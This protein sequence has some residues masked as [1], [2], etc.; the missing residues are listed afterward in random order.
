MI[1]PLVRRIVGI[2]VL[3]GVTAACLPYL[4]SGRSPSET[5]N[6]LGISISQTTDKRKT[7]ADRSTVRLQGQRGK[8]GD[9]L[10]EAPD[11][12]Q[13]DV[14][15]PDGKK[16][17]ADDG[18]KGRK[19]A[20]T[21]EGDPDEPV[22]PSD[23][24][25]RTIQKQQ[26]EEEKAQQARRQAEAARKAEAEK[27]AAADAR[28]RKEADERKAAEA[29]KLAE[30]QKAARQSVEEKK[31]AEKRAAEEK[32][33]SE[34]ERIAAARKAAE[35]K[36]AAEKKAAEE[37]S[38]TAAASAAEERKKAQPAKAAAEQKAFASG[39]NA[40]KYRDSLRSNGYPNARME[41][42]TR[43]GRVLFRV[44]PGESN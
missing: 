41:P 31:A 22:M 9:A 38:K 18:E 12:E 16:A 20:V 24:E 14:R 34:R 44:V 30:R 27:K 4:T 13:I 11:Q 1:S 7:F 43:D 37:R 2:S 29:R 42:I 39:L 8:A 21:P 6:N 35:E 40:V 25:R 23:E 19:A 15:E 5:A 3:L 33:A 10:P 26:A 28:A 17:S 32:K 36:R